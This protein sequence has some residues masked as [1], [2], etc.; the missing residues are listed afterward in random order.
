MTMKKLIVSTLAFLIF[1]G[2]SSSGVKKNT[3]QMESI[4]W[5]LPTPESIYEEADVIK[6]KNLFEIVPGPQQFSVETRKEPGKTVYL[7]DLIL[8][9]K[10]K[11]R[12]DIDIDKVLSSDVGLAKSIANIDFLLLDRNG[13]RITVESGWG[14][15]SLS[16][17]LFNDRDFNTELFVNYLSD[18]QSEPGKEFQLH[19]WADFS[20]PEA[21]CYIGFSNLIKE[22]KGVELRMVGSDEQFEKYIGFIE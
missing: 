21:K 1:M 16:L 14:P 5:V 8:N 3:I 2:C 9:V 4:K 18:L 15:Q 17:I 19:A 6:Q 10:L 12:V 7:L 22:V 11:H 13:E 20:E